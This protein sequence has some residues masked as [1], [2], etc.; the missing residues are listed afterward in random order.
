[1][2]GAAC[3]N[4]GAIPVHSSGTS[5]EYRSSTP[6]SSDPVARPKVWAYPT[7]FARAA[8][9][10]ARAQA[11]PVRNRTRGVGP[12]VVA[13]EGDSCV[14]EPGALTGRAAIGVFRDH[15]GL[16]AIEGVKHLTAVP[17][18]K[19][20]PLI[21]SYAQGEVLVVSLRWRASSYF[22]PRRGP[23]VTVRP[24]RRSPGAQSRRVECSISAD[25]DRLNSHD[26]YVD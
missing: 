20:V 18:V 5:F 19:R 15:V 16:E 23:V 17:A 9:P 4:N 13:V 22:T 10:S 7:W 11:E 2:V 12:S 8:I 6:R 26:R 25:F 24:R 3:Y 21:C 1:M 14:N